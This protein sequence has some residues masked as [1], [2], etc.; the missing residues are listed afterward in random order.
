[1]YENAKQL[2]A[3][4]YFLLDHVNKHGF[5]KILSQQ[6]ILLVPSFLHM[7]VVVKE[8]PLTHFLHDNLKDLLVYQC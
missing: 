5:Y 2:A 7:Q 6:S 4:F 3:I 8:T 1:M